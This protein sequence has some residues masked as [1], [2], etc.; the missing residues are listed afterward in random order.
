[1]RYGF[2]G[3]R[4]VSGMRSGFGAEGRVESGLCIGILIEFVGK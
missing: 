3:L 2:V 4:F 1:M